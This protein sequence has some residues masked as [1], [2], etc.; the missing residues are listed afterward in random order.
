MSRGRCCIAAKT[1]IEALKEAAL[2]AI[3]RVQVVDGTMHP[4]EDFDAVLDFCQ[5]RTEDL[6]GAAGSD[7]WY[8]WTVG[9]FAVMG[10]LGQL[11]QT[12]TAAIAK[13]SEI[14]GEGVYCCAIDAHFNYV[15]FSA[16]E[17][18]EQKRLLVL[19]D[20]LIVMDGLP[21]EAE[22]GRPTV[23]F[24]VEEGERMWTFYGLPTFEFDPEGGPFQCVELKTS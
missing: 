18:G 16:Y 22:H 10:D 7:A 13:M 1:T 19:E 15:H 21:I 4:C 5:P 6:G 17:E 20:E 24:S 23:D 8:F 3:D 9:D 12:D 11:L 2:K 14:L